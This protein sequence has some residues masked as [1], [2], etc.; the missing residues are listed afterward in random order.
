MAKEWLLLR[1]GGDRELW[2]PETWWVVFCWDKIL[3]CRWHL[4]HLPGDKVYKTGLKAVPGVYSF[5][6]TPWG[7]PRKVQRV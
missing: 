5:L 2:A 6:P 4:E 7:P 3:S 1:E